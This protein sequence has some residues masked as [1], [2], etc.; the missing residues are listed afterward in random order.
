MKS[1]SESQLIEQSKQAK[2]LIVDARTPGEYRL[3][4]ITGATN[5]PLDQFPDHVDTLKQYDHVIVYCNS[6][7]TSSQFIHRAEQAW[8]DHCINLTGWI[9]SCKSCP[10]T[11]TKWPLPIMRQ[12][13][14]AAGSLVLVGVILSLVFGQWWI[15][16]STFVG[17]GLTFAG[18]SGR[19]GM[20]KLLAM[21]PWN[22]D[23]STPAHHHTITAKDVIIKQFEDKKLAHYSYV[24]MSNGQAIVVD[25]ERNP[26]KYYDFISSHHATLVWIYNTHPH[27]DFASGHLQMYE[28]MSATIYV[29]DKVG[30]DYPHTALQWGEVIDFGSA[31]VTAYFTPGHSPDSMSYLIKDSDHKQVWLCTGDWVFIGDVGRADLRESVGNLKAAQAELAAQMYETT[32]S[33]LPTLDQSLMLLPAHGAGTSCG[34]WLSTMP[35][36]TLANQMR[37]NPMLQD[38]SKE[39]FV[40]ELTSDQL[41]IPAYFTHS[42]L[43]NKAGNTSIDEAMSSITYLDQLPVDTTI[44]D[45]RARATATNYPLSQTSLIIPHQNPGFVGTLGAMIAGDEHY[46]LIVETHADAAQVIRDVLSI[47]YEDHL[48]GIYVIEDQWAHELIVHHRDLTGE[49]IILDVRSAAAHAANPY[50]ASQVINIPLEQLASRHAELDKTTTYI[51]Y[52][53]WSYK[54][55]V[56]WSWL[57]AHGYQSRKMYV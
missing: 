8:L 14:V 37:Y 35:M 42:V 4:H 10:I 29:G 5:L 28:D 39:A 18:V 47:G 55:D 17:A 46:I 43:L 40:T 44:I 30:A 53:G 49:E 7:N 25:P 15:A 26:Q 52:C 36:D 45:T 34:K 2:T 32:R 56:A 11:T 20:A 12:V 50:S 38:M 19:C 24:A 51:P 33:I 57:L 23:P 22:R 31:S 16:L 6:G 1:I 13:Q 21:M 48:D 41:S 27:A 54:S 3:Q 9:S